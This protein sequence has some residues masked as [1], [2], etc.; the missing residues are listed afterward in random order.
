MTEYKPGT[1]S[2]LA[3][4]YSKNMN[5][6]RKPGTIFECMAP[7]APLSETEYEIDWSTLRR[8]EQGA[9]MVCAKP[10]PQ[11]IQINIEVYNETYR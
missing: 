11:K 5:M 6:A 10:K 2:S 8:N 7:E 1:I 3:P 4:K 9:Y